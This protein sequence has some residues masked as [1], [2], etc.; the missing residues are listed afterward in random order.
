MQELPI[1]DASG[2]I[3]KINPHVL[4]EFFV[5]N[6][7]KV[8]FISDKINQIQLLYTV[9]KKIDAEIKEEFNNILTK[10]NAVELVNLTVKKVDS[11]DIEPNGKTI[12]VKINFKL[13]A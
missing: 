7:N 4:N 13:P 6:M 3:L 11:I 10:Y 1:M 8:Q 9:S 12:L 2:E 5:P